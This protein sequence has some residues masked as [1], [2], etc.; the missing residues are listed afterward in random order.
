MDRVVELYAEHAFWFWAALAALVLAIEV[1]TGTGWLLWASASAA[2][3]AVATA[4][5]EMS[6]AAEVGL[7]AVLTLV[8]SLL[9]HRFWPAQREVSPDI[10]DNIGRLIGRE[11]RVVY[12]GPGRG[13]VEIDGKEW[14][15][16]S[17]AEL[18]VGATVKVIRVEG[19]TLGVRA[20]D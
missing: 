2:A 14:A 19:S 5:I 15:A 18:I 8:T 17:E 3:V 20:A 16:D 7:F 6:F 12:A 9:A 10:N 13:R 1:A 11:A 4:L